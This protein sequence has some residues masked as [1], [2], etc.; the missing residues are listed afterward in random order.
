MASGREFHEGVLSGSRWLSGE[1]RVGPPSP[2]P[3][4]KNRHGGQSLKSHRQMP[5]PEE[6][7]EYL[8]I[9]RLYQTRQNINGKLY[10]ENRP[11]HRLQCG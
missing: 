9:P 3:G 11:C 6:Q 4:M 2:G 10:G 5:G 7:P 1:L 8:S